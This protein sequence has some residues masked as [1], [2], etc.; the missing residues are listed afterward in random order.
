MHWFKENRDRDARRR[1]SALACLFG[2][3]F[4]YT[5][6][7]AVALVTGAGICC[8]GDRC[9][10]AGH[11]HAA[12]KAESATQDCGHAMQQDKNRMD[13]CSL[14]CCQTSSPVAFHA[15][16]AHRIA[17]AVRGDIARP[18]AAQQERAVGQLFER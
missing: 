10:V 11:H 6:V 7:A 15:L 2:L 18:A 17:T 13:A 1:L 9:P 16:L 12:T 8:G 3:S 5:Q 4:F 14:S